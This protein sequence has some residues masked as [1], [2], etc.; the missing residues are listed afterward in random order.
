[1]SRSIYVVALLVATA[2][3]D[4]GVAPADTDQA[5]T[6]VT[7]SA[8]DTA[9]A[10]GSGSPT[11]PDSDTAPTDGTTSQSTGIDPTS[12]DGSTSGPGGSSSTTGGGT[13]PGAPVLYVAGGDAVTVWSIDDVGALTQVQ[14]ADQGGNVGPLAA[15]GASYL[16]AARVNTQEVSAMTIDPTTGSLT[17]VAVTNV[18]HRPVYMSVDPSGSWLLS[19]DFGGDLVQVRPLEADGSVGA[20]PS[21]TRNV[22]SRPHAIVFDPGGDYVFVPHRDSNLVEQ[23]LFDD[24]TGMLTPNDPPSV[25][26][27]KGVGP[28]HIA[29]ADD[30][31]YAYVV[32][33]FDSSVTVYAYDAGAGLLTQGITVPALPK[34]FMG[35]N[36]GADIHVTPDGGTVYASMRGQDSLAIFEVVGDGTISYQGFAG[37]PARPREFGL[38]PFGRFVY[39]AGQDDGMLRGYTIEADGALSPG[40]LYPVGANAQW[41]LGVELPPVR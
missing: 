20:K 17:E 27:P 38:G 3:S 6:A 11:G 22:Q 15:F 39:A 12:A 4:D 29:F 23:Y 36:T 34:G 2:C 37:T 26:A 30:S 8:S 9:D 33:E 18:G 32:N 41:V 31:T 25:A 10:A 16:Y 13:G 21:Q 19:A 24:T 14:Q 40:E 35:E 5:T 1:M 7:A 28:R